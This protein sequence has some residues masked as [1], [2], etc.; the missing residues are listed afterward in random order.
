MTAPT[1]DRAEWRDMGDFTIR[2]AE[3]YE[4]CLLKEKEYGALISAAP[5]LLRA[6]LDALSDVESDASS[7][8]WLPNHTQ[9]A[10]RKAIRKANGNG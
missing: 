5:D 3:S 4:V 9:E 6:C 1:L 8:N 10:L 7:E 2:D